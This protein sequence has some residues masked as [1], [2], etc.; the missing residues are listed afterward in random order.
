M[1]ASADQISQEL[2]ER[3]AAAERKTATLRVRARRAAGRARP[4]LPALVALAAGSV[5]G[6]GVALVVSRS[7]PA[8]HPIAEQLSELARWA[9]TAAQRMGSP[10]IR[11][12]IGP[13]QRPD[14]DRRGE[15][16]RERL[17]Q[18]AQAGGSA[19]ASAAAAALTSRLLGPE[20]RESK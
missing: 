9:R 19:A 16:R 14:P 6:V 2:T 20:R 15:H 7:R 4:V 1:G 11:V 3:R 5:S 12:E 10:M 18:L 13:Q 8:H 17:L